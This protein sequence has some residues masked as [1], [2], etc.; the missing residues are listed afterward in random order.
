MNR[1]L[2]T[3]IGLLL[4]AAPAWAH[5]VRPG[6]LELTQTAPDTFQTVWKVPSRGELRLALFPVF[7]EARTPSTEIT[8][9]RT[10]GAGEAD[11]EKRPLKGRRAAGKKLEVHLDVNPEYRI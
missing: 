11:L 3:L 10:P 7:P 5:E 9:V 2:A 8:R 4:V 6:Y 1:H